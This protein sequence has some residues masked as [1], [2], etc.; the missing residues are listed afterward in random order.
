MSRTEFFH[1]LRIVVPVTLAAILFGYLVITVM[2]YFIG[3][4]DAKLHY[5][6]ATLFP[7]VLTPVTIFPLAVMSQRLRSAKH[8][9]EALL[10]ID[11]MTGLPNRRAFFEHAED[12]YARGK[13]VSLMM[14]DVDHFKAVN[15][16]FGHDAGD[17]VIRTVAQA[18]A[19]LVKATPGAGER[20]TA[21]F[22]GEEFAVLL[23]GIDNETAGRLA[24]RIVER[25][26]DAPT[27]YSG[28][29]IP[30]TVSVGVAERQGNERVDDTL[31]SADNACYRAKRLGRNQWR[32][33]DE[34]PGRT[35]PEAEPGALRLRPRQTLAG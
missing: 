21:R 1:A 8:Q 4:R 12:I 5:T 17:V 26:G 19:Q 35:P 10:R 3:F 11:A 13:A 34:V 18:I 31:R 24:G 27:L 23:E 16:S 29:I 6:L 7:L 2:L 32:A 14:I 22:G 15:D 28:S 25:L 30:T 9:L 20:I 33:A